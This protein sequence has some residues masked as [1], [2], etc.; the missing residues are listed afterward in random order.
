[1]ADI[2]LFKKVQESLYQFVKQVAITYLH[3]P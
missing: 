2:P 1:L 3:I